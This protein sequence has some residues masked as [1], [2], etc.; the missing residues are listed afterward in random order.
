MSTY[1]GYELHSR[2]IINYFKD[3]QYKLKDI[4]PIHIEEYYNYMLTHGKVNPITNERIGLSIR[5]VRSHK[6]IIKSALDKAVIN[7]LIKSNPAN[8]VKV[9]NKKNKDLARPIHFFTSEQANQFIRFVNDKDD[10]LADLIFITLYYGLRRSEVLGLT[11]KSVDLEQKRLYIKRTIVKVNDTHDNE[12]TKTKASEASFVIT[13]DMIPFFMRVIAKKKENKQFYGNEY[14]DSDFLLTWQ[15]G[16]A[17]APD[18][19]YHHFKD[20]VKEFGRTEMTF[21]GLRHSCA[22]ILYEK[23]WSPKD[24][25]MWLRHADFYTTMNIYT[26][27][28]NFFN[29]ERAENMVGI[30]QIPD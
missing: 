16:H 25:Q 5:T 10:V 26:H 7:D 2:H 1:E 30:L 28:D 24:I 21:H 17:F 8:S 4:R 29:T 6:F 13:D 27:I 15:D 18:Y 19:I 9:T 12:Q 3:K 22:S 23:G 11:L 20:L 14:A